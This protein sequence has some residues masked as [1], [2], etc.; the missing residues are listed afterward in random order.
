M[1]IAFALLFVCILMCSFI[2]FV[3]TQTPTADGWC[4]HYP[5]R[6]HHF[7]D[8]YVNRPKLS[9]L[10]V[11]I[12]KACCLSTLAAELVAAV[13]A[14]AA[15]EWL[16]GC[17]R[18]IRRNSFRQ[19]DALRAAGE[20]AEVDCGVI[21][22]FECYHPIFLVD[23]CL[24]PSISHHSEINN[25]PVI[26]TQVN[27]DCCFVA[28]CLAIPHFHKSFVF[29]TEILNYSMNACVCWRRWKDPRWWAIICIIDMQ[30]R[31]NA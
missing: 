5:Y 8:C 30:R 18:N 21:S 2:F 23:C 16:R 31:D 25:K 3:G 15:P 28:G 20:V 6:I 29:L 4:G 19:A 1:I 17:F 14:F 22:R 24:V 7:V 26:N 10:A 9:A 27:V 12:V 11:W 13:V